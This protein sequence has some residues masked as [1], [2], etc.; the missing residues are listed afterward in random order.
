ML[1]CARMWA[2]ATVHK[3]FYGLGYKSSAMWLCRWTSDCRRFEGSS[4][5]RVLCCCPVCVASEQ[6]TVCAVGGLFVVHFLHVS[7]EKDDWLCVL[8]CL[9][10]ADCSSFSS[11]TFSLQYALTL[12][13]PQ[14][15]G[16][17]ILNVMYV[18]MCVCVCV[19]IYIYIYMCVCVCVCVCNTGWHKKKGTFEKPNKKWR[20][21]RK[22]LL[23]EI[24]PLQLAF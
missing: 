5:F 2:S 15:N 19:Y 4:S 22:K 24:E 17:L 6:S 14:S 16:V 12:L 10:S 11:D 13:F 7:A 8:V 20:N 1:Y 9:R 18:C 3:P 21:P 23:T